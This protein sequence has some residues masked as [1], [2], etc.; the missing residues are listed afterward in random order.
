MALVPPLKSI[1]IF[2]AKPFSVSLHIA[3]SVSP[4]ERSS[5]LMAGADPSAVVAMKIFMQRNQVA[6]E[7]V[8]LEFFRAAENRPAPMLIA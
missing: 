7:R 6:P 1:D 2:Q 5:S 3:E 4:P 8:L